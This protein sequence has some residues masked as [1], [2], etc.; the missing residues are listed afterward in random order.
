MNHSIRRHLLTN[1]TIALL[2]SS[3]I[4]SA[5]TYMVAGEELD[6]LYD[7]NM[8]QVALALLSQYGDNPREQPDNRKNLGKLDGQEKFLI[9]V[10]GKDKTLLYTSHPTISIPEQ[11][12]QGYGS[13][14]FDDKEWRYFSGSGNGVTVQTFQPMEERHEVIMEVSSKFLIPLLL[15]IPL[16]GLLIWWTVGK[17][18]KP[19]T[20]VSRAI[21]TRSSKALQPL[22][23]EDLPQE[24]KPLVLALNELL[25]RLDS[26]LKAQRRFT[27]DAAHE[28]RTPL[29]A[30]QLQLDLLKRSKSENDKNEALE[31]LASGI[32]RSIHVVRQLLSLAHQEP[33]AKEQTFET[34]DL[35]T[36]LYEAA[37]PFEAVAQQ[38]N[39]TLH[40][41]KREKPANVM[42]NISSLRILIENLLD[43]AIRYT[44]EGGKVEASIAS[45]G[46]AVTLCIAD[47]GSGIPQEERDRVFDRF[48]RITGTEQSGTGLGLSIVKQIAERHKASI[49]LGD[50][51]DGKGLAARILFPT[52]RSPTH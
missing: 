28:L 4:I 1:L 35:A 11:S 14:Q 43:N 16:L 23:S 17:S 40:V 12:A 27:A 41:S 37:V 33:E 44:P 10:W 3:V 36:V 15:Q 48:Y 13:L 19:L 7:E 20:D 51:I 30:V 21:G 52:A 29:T 45:Q 49:V 38:K 6:E 2:V 24:I 31:K 32:K 9:Q 26:A 5:V 46:D 18:L 34:L 50:G 22:P 42:G 47:S 25:E 8:Q 39:I